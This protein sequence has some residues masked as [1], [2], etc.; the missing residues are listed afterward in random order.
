MCG[1]YAHN[2]FRLQ[3]FPVYVC[4]CRVTRQSLAE[5]IPSLIGLLVPTHNK[6]VPCNAHNVNKLPIQNND[7]P[8]CKYTNIQSQN[9][10]AAHVPSKPAGKIHPAEIGLHT[11]SSDIES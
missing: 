3:V 10:T 6:T 7:P 9:K 2:G 8:H 4:I 11:E 5:C 1:T